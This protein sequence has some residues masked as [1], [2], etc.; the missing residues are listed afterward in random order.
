MEY[1]EGER[2]DH[3]CDTNQLTTDERLGLFKKVCYAVH[4]A[5]Q[6]L[7]IHRDLKPGNILV[8]PQGE[9]K[10][11]DFGIARLVD[12]SPYST[13]AETLRQTTGGFLGTLRYASP[14]QVRNDEVITTASDVYSLGTLLYELLTGHYPF[15]KWNRSFLD[16]VNA[17]CKR[18]PD[19]PSTAVTL[20]EEV[21][22]ADG[23]QTS[24]TP[25]EICEARRDKPSLSRLRRSLT[26]DL[27]RIVLKALSK[28][29]EDRYGSAQELAEDIDRHLNR[30]PVAACEPTFTYQ[31][32]KFIRRHKGPVITAAGLV[33]M[34]LIFG[35]VV[36]WYWKEEERARLETEEALFISDYLVDAFKIGKP[37]SEGT[38]VSARELLD[39]TIPKLEILARIPDLPQEQQ[40]ELASQRPPDLPALLD[41][42]GWAYY[43]LGASDAAGTWLEQSVAR[44]PEP[45]SPQDRRQLVLSQLHLSVTREALGRDEEAASLWADASAAVRNGEVDS[46]RMAKRLN[47][48]ANLLYERGETEKAVELF[49]QSVAMKRRELKNP[50]DISMVFAL[51]NLAVL[52]QGQGD[53]AE[54][55]TYFREALAIS[56]SKYGDASGS[57]EKA[58][59]GLANLLRDL[60]RVQPE[61]QL[62]A[63]DDSEELFRQS[64]A[65]RRAAY[66]AGDHRIAPVLNN[67]ALLLIY[68]GKLAEAE[69]LLDEALQIFRK[70][71]GERDRVVGVVLR[72]RATLWQAKGDF[73][74]AERE[75]RQAVEI[76]EGAMGADHWN[77]KDA[78]SVLGGCL[79]DLNRVEE[80]TPLIE[81]SLPILEEI[82]GENARVT[83]EA[84]QRSRRLAEKQADG[85]VPE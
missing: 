19:K 80:A 40:D 73:E 36:F 61:R 27:D 17:I 46:L 18:E 14:E 25:E 56:Q 74:A 4:F 77:T 47:E 71:Y 72:N 23:S 28:Q 42:I 10:L 26:G 68:R 35:L 16:L 58:Q 65:R 43:S 63:W 13:S 49:R 69:E 6:N 39:R 57:V 70:G 38:D 20:R 76:F 50:D 3:Y 32:G 1:V 21:P 54:G 66:A 11:L 31:L 75:A 48:M 9:P 81:E 51:H 60:G 37:A 22:S 15:Q 79:L 83:W 78:R 82:K 52:L 33:L 67:L 7:I 44:R 85:T 45:E 8:T 24:V 12:P 30:E 53:Y 2:I 34:I 55:E 62:E 59:N 29:P 5:H 84:W 41:A 64:L